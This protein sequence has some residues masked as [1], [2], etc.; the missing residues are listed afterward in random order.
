MRPPFNEVA[1]YVRDHSGCTT[2]EIIA[3]FIERG[4]EIDR[5]WFWDEIAPK[6]IALGCGTE[7]VP[8]RMH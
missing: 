6:L 3:A 4:Y 7:A 5:R 1:D 8:A 2:N